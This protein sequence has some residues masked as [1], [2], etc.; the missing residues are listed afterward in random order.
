MEWIIAF[1][2]CIFVILIAYGLHGSN[3]SWSNIIWITPILVNPNLL[4]GEQNGEGIYTNILIMYIFVWGVY[5]SFFNKRVKELDLKNKDLYFIQALL[6]LQIFVSVFQ[7]LTLEIRS[8]NIWFND[9]TFVISIIFIIQT[10]RMLNLNENKKYFNNIIKGILIISLINSML[11]IIQYIFK[12]TFLIFNNEATVF[13]TEGAKE[14]IRVIGLVGANNG[15]GNLGAL[16]FSI[17]L[18]SLY[19][20]RNMLTINAFS[21][22]IIFTILTF[23]RIA[24][25]SILVQLLIFL[26]YITVKSI[27]KN[28]VK[29]VSL[30]NFSIALTCILAILAFVSDDLYRIFI[31]DRGNTTDSRF[32][33]FYY[34]FNYVFATN[35]FDFVG[36]GAGNYTYYLYENYG[37]YDIVIHSFFLN[38]LVEKGILSF[39]SFVLIYILIFKE[40]YKILPKENKWISFSVVFGYLI[41]INGNP[42]QYYLL[43]NILFFLFCFS[44]VFRYRNVK[45]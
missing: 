17:T 45:V 3:S 30:I 7:I 38:T 9:L 6:F 21:F 22:N 26:I 34:I 4:L 1:F 19:K 13:Y 43:P 28:S 27:R 39:M 20:K 18:F 2:F 15:A 41:V 16:L 25:I 8:Y 23:T 32:L 40:M 36:I 11:G 29:I 44:I 5:S 31:V 37:I 33:Q 12:K 10:L 24:I 14:G 42:S 35:K